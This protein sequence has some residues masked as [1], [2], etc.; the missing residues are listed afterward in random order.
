MTTL[1]LCNV[2]M[3][4]APLVEVVPAAAGAGFDG[5]TVSARSHARAVRDGVASADLRTLAAD[6]GVRITDVE[7]AGDWLGAEPDDVPERLRTTV[8]TTDQLLTVAAELGATTLTAVHAGERRPLD[9]SAAAFAR[10]CDRAAEVGLQVALEFVA[11]MGIASL[12]DGWDVVR[13]ADRPNGGLLVDVWH[14][15]RTSAS[16]ALLEEIPPERILSVQLCD[17]EAEPRGPLPEDVTRR[18]LPGRG[19]LDVVGFVRTLLACGVA[20]PIGVEAFDAQLV[21]QGVPEAAH[22][23]HDELA[24]VVDAAR[25][26]ASAG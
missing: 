4:T 8:Y 1:V 15:R 2:S 22:V 21:A 10:L 24:A 16:D 14:H 13:T 7:A 19:A 25:R 20:A 9:Q 5:I 3:L 26:P 23:L 18:T 12:A 17:A 11:W 6:H